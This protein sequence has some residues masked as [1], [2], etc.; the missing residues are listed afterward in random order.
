MNV[1]T[2]RSDFV[3]KVECCSEFVG[4]HEGLEDT[5]YDVIKKFGA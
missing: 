5:Q 3:R 4:T 1:G 2:R